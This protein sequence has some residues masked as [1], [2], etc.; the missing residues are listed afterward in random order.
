VKRT[1]KDAAIECEMF[2][3]LAAVT[4][5]SDISSNE[6]KSVYEKHKEW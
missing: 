2:E 6:A 3:A 5:T 4:K 1:L